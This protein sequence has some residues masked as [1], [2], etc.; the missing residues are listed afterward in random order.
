[1]LYDLE[2]SMIIKSQILSGSKLSENKLPIFSKCDFLKIS[3]ESNGNFSTLGL[4]QD[5][6]SKH[7]LCL[8]ATGA[9]KTNLLLSLTSQIKENLTENDILMIF[10]SKYDFR[11]L[12]SHND[13]VISNKNNTSINTVYPNLFMD[14]VADGWD[15]EEI[16]INAFEIA[17][18]VFMDAIKNSSQAFFPKSASEIFASVLCGMALMGADDM[19]F[20][21][22]YLNNKAL[23]KYLRSLDA[24]KLADFVKPFPL[25]SG[26]TKYVG[27]GKSDQA[28]G[29]FAEL[30]NGIS[31]LLTR[32][33]GKDGRFS[34]RKAV[35]NRGGKTIFLEY[36]PSCGANTTMYRV[37]VDLFLKESLSPDHKK[38]HVYL[39]ADELSLLPSLNYFETALNFG[40]SLNLSLI[41]GLQSIE[42]LYETYGEYGGNNIASAFQNCFSFRTNNEASRSY[43]KGL[44]G[45]NLINL[46]YL[47]SSNLPQQHI[48]EG[49]TIEDDDIT[50]LRN[51]EAIVSLPGKLPFIFRPKLY[52]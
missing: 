27:S 43:I 38:G 24:K 4:S 34:I 40:R 9:G 33:F 3:G 50:T 52:K 51:G 49:N 20:R 21:I 12:Q 48:R 29:V 1:M 19:S 44:H 11:H 30:Q 37:L 23:S 18:V 31:P 28:L 7:V 26:V 2:V 6:I 46:Q 15:E 10:D 36:D 35:R 32:N 8:G 39:I 17:K 41:C 22:K 16:F 45:K 42:Q 14:I 5:L 25:L 13:Y 47:D